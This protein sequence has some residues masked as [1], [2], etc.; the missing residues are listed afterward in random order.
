MAYV[1]LGKIGTGPAS[2]LSVFADDN[3]AYSIEASGTNVGSNTL[4]SLKTIYRKIGCNIN[5]LV[6]GT[7]VNQVV[8]LFTLNDGTYI[9][10]K[11]LE[12]ELNKDYGSNYPWIADI[13]RFRFD[14]Y[15]SNGTVKTS[16]TPANYQYSTDYRIIRKSD[17]AI[18]LGTSLLSICIDDEN[19]KAFWKLYFSDSVYGTFALNT[20]DR[21]I[22]DGVSTTTLYNVLQGSGVEY[23]P[24]PWSNAGYGDIGGGDGQLDLTSDVIELPPLPTSFVETGFVQIFAPSLSQIN[25][26]SDYMWK[27][28]FFNELTKLFSNPMDIIISLSMFPFSIPKDGYRYVHAGNIVTLIQM[29]LPQSQYVTIDC[30]TI[31]V[32]HFYDAYLDYEPYTSCQIYLPYVGVQALS[33]DDIMGKTLHVLYRVDLMTGTCCAYILCNDIL[34]YTFTGACSAQIPVNGQSYQSMAQS[35]I[36]I[37]TSTAL[38]KGKHTKSNGAV[39]PSQKG[40]AFVGSVASNV[41]S[42]KPDVMRTGSISSNVGMLSPQKPYLIFSVPRTCLPKGQ[43][44]YMGYPAFMTVKLSGLKGYTEIESIRLNNISCTEEEKI[45]I[46]ELLKEGVVL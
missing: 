37:A 46:T 44:K 43:N 12:V 35:I 21:S 42:C 20:T 36:N 14:H 32:K 7:T 9:G 2:D 13:Y 15:N 23:D 18:L 30:G 4:Q 17:N 16:L 22:M 25:E 10:I 40:S 26:L 29:D 45:E 19:K 24:D 33:M 5:D 31:E 38:A 28:G 39:V 8:K 41:M 6:V 11:M 27:G 34:L 1:Q 3:R